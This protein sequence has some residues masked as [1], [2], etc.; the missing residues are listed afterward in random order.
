MNA[1]V[2][3]GLVLAQTNAPS[4]TIKT[5]PDDQIQDIRPPY[6]YLNSTPWWLFVLAALALAGLGVLLYFLLRPR[7]R[8]SARS[9]YE[10]A[11]EKLEAARALLRE[12]SAMPYAVMVSE[13]VRVYLG[14]RF[15]APSPRRTTEEFLRQMEADRATPLAEHRE[16]LRDFLQSLRPGQVRALPAHAG[17]TRARA[18]ARQRLRP[19]HQ[20]AGAH[21]QREAPMT[22]QYAFAHPWVLAFLLL[23]PAIAILR[24]RWGKAAAVE[25]SGLGLFGELARQRRSRAGGW[26]SA[27]RYLA[28]AAFI[29]ALARPQKVDSSS[30]VQESGIDMMLAIDLSPSMEALDYHENGEEISRVQVVRETVGKFIQARP[31]DRIGMVAFAG[32]AYLMSPLTLDHDWLLQNVERL[33]VG[34][35][36]DATAIGSALATCA[37]RLRNEPSKSKIIVLLTDGANNA[38]KITPLAA[39]EAA[40]A[41]GIKIYTIGAGSADVAKFPT[42][43]IFGQRVYTTIPVDIDEGALQRIADVGGGKFYRAADTETLKHVYD[44]INELETT[45]VATKQYHHYTEYFMWAMYPGL[46]FLGLEITLAHTRL[47][48][49]P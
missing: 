7:R 12:E 39:A 3:L 40:H 45:K 46:L 18:A 47:R 25:Y 6:F 38:G 30:Q 19:R 42:R 24:G 48:R 49:I 35:A 21:C 41:L 32:E 4:I 26:L 11:L 2:L 29:V 22:T 1:P 28:L 5:R 20:A 43:N 9:A 14:Q 10:L 27:L 16:L 33:H 37:N 13:T 34:L 17:R 23:L 8:L 44:Q 15:H 31:N 36:G